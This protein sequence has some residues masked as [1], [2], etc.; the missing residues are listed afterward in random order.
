MVFLFIPNIIGY[1]RAGL[2]VAAMWFSLSHPILT[3]VCYGLSQ[4]MDLF[5][6]MA[7]RHFDQSTKFGAVLDMVCD[8]VSDAVMLAILAALYPEYCWFFYLDIALDIGSHWYQ[9]YATLAC[10][11]KHHKEAKSNYWLLELYYGNK[12]VLFTLVAGNEVTVTLLQIFFLS[13]YLNGFRKQ[14]GMSDSLINL[15]Y[16]VLL[17]SLVL[18][19]IKKVQHQIDIAYERCTVDERLPE[20]RRPRHKRTRRT[21]SKESVMSVV[22]VSLQRIN[23]KFLEEV[24]LQ[25]GPVSF[26]THNQEKFSNWQEP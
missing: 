16:A 21:T 13:A 17:V 12:K 1:V 23:I 8:R 5:D 20:T 6:G 2:L 4:L 18:F 24:H 11:E 26:R 25:D 10:G 3:M 15:N 9:M 14:L 22:T 19:L 7:A